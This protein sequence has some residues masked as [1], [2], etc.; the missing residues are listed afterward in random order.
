MNGTVG[1]LLTNPLRALSEN[2]FF[3]FILNLIDGI[4]AQS[5]KAK[6]GQPVE[7]RFHDIATG[8]IHIISNPRPPGG[9]TGGIEEVG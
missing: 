3:G 8:R 6:L 1:Y 4:E 9:G 2:V 5:I 7:R